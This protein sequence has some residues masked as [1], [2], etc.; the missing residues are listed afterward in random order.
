MMAPWSTIGWAQNCASG[1]NGQTINCAGPNGCTGSV[2]INYPNG[3]YGRSQLCTT[4]EH[5]CGQLITTSYVCGGCSALKAWATPELRE[6][7][8]KVSLETE[9]LVAD[10]SGHYEPL[11]SLA[12]PANTPAGL[13]FLNDHVLR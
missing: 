13:A 4:A 11:K 3:D 2:Y 6:R 7:L 5:C 8:A 10:C 12:P 1:L 9:L